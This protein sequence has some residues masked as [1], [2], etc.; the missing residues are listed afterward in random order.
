[1][2]PLK[3]LT[4]DEFFNELG[5]KDGAYTG[6]AGIGL[7]SMLSAAI[8]QFIFELQLGK[9]KY[10][11]QQEEIEQ[12][13]N[14]SISLREDFLKLTVEDSE[15]FDQVLVA[16]KMPKDTEEEQKERRFAIDSGF[17]ESSRPLLALEAKLLELLQLYEAM[18]DLKVSGS[19]LSDALMTLQFIRA[20]A[21]GA[22]R[23]IENNLAA[24]KESEH[25]E[26]LQATL[27]ETVEQI[28]AKI[29]SL[30]QEIDGILNE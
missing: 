2:K 6:G 19:I 18:V 29:T 24:V 21:V 13:V 23:M 27:D 17:I 20:V 10:L 14:C 1:M 11:E 8:T 30:E 5:S 4:I 7:V 16:F 28:F 3:D 25:A 22:Q 26:E 12:L 9:K 15:V